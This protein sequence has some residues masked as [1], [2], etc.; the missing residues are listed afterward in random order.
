MTRTFQLAT[1]SATLAVALAATPLAAA[2]ASEDSLLAPVIARIEAEGYRLIETHRSWLGR[3][4]I[5]SQKDGI[6]REMVLNR[7]T[8]AVL[9]DRLFTTAA[10]ATPA[11]SA[12]ADPTTTAP[13]APAPG[14]GPAPAAGNPGAQSNGSGSAAGP[15]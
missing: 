3:L 4:V 1:L 12:P 14:A 8:G 9:S 7:S 13:A 5:T 11:P 6:L 15:N 2:A 10:Q